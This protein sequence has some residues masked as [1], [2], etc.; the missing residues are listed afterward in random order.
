[1]TVRETKQA[2]ELV[3]ATILLRR[4][5]SHQGDVT[6]PDLHELFEMERLV[7]SAKFFTYDAFARFVRNQPDL[8]VVAVPKGQRTSSVLLLDL[9]SA[10]FAASRTGESKTI[11]F[12]AIKAR[13]RCQP[14]GDLSCSLEPAEVSA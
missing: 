8:T 2:R 6:L 12:E 7:V 13:H 11:D 1:M 3:L 4:I 9:P 14:L 10:M 5:R